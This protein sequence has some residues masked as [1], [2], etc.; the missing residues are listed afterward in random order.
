MKVFYLFIVICLS[1]SCKDET[2]ENPPLKGDCFLLGN[3]WKFYFV[4]KERK[5]IIGLKAGQILPTTEIQPSPYFRPSTIPEG[6]ENNGKSYFYNGNANTIGFEPETGLYFW[7]TVIPGY[8]YLTNHSFYIHFNHTDI[9]TVE[10]KFRFQYEDV[11]GGDFTAQVKELRYNGTLVI[12][13]NEYMD[14]AGIYIQ[15]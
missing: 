4:D 5:S 14:K 13:N 9:D 2:R 8:E 3:P 7:T 6:Y 10:V 1:F 11:Y 15:K 12:K